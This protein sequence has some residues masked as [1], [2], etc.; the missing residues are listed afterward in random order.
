VE[1]IAIRDG[2]LQDLPEL[3]AIYNEVL[4]N[5]TAIWSDEPRTLE[6]HQAWFTERTARGLPVLVLGTADRILGYATFGPFRTW[7]GYDKTVESSIYLGP[8][9]RAQGL[10]TRLLTALVERGKALGFHVMIAGIDAENIASIRLHQK[11]GFEQAAHFHQVGRKFGRW[12][13]LLCLE[14]RLGATTVGPA[15]G[16]DGPSRRS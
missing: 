1:E 5:S 13:D 2:R 10:G 7:S 16:G 12:L 15:G 4:L 3:L 6:G 8:G 14:L 11:L 9:S